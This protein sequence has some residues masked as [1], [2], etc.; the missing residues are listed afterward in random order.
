MRQLRWMALLSVCALQVFAETIDKAPLYGEL[1]RHYEQA[2]L[3]APERGYVVTSRE[4]LRTTDGGGNWTLLKE[5]P[6]GQEIVSLFF[7]DERR[8]WISTAT[9]LYRTRD[10]LATFESK[11]ISFERWDAEPGQTG[12]IA[13]DIVFLDDNHG[14]A[15]DAHHVIHTEDGGQT[16]RPMM[17]STRIGGIVRV[18]M[19]S[20][21]EGFVLTNQGVYRTTD[22]W[23]KYTLQPGSPTNLHEVECH[24]RFC[25]AA[26]SLGEPRQFFFSFDGGSTWSLQQPGLRGT[27]DRP[28]NW[29]LSS[30]ARVRIFGTDVGYYKLSEL[31]EG[32]YRRSAQPTSF[33]LT[34]DGTAWS[35]LNIPSI[36]SIGHVQFVDDQH[37]WAVAG[38]NNIFRSDDGGHTWYTVQDYFRRQ[39]PA[40]LRPLFGN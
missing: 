28:N 24:S 15:V 5:F 26:T 33:I 27:R 8:F 1:T 34:W 23:R 7:L 37:A 16:W 35:R 11:T 31:N 4:I 13:P 32:A 2:Y 3:W 36:A 14:W 19:F 29:Q 20:E 25:V 21:T 40:F 6:K 17:R 10:G 18:W 39:V 9:G 12:D 38:D 22:G 30:E